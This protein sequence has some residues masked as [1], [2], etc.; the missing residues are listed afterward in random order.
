M[1]APAHFVAGGRFTPQLELRELV[2]PIVVIDISRRAESDPD[3]VVDADDLR[4]FERRHG[5]IPDGALVAMDSGWAGRSATR[6]P[7]RAARSA[8]ITSPASATRRSRTCSSGAT[9]RRSASTR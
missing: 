9:R 1:D 6:P 2:L 4:R 3:A 8:T 7:T 5:R